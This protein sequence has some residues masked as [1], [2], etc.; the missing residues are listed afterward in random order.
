MIT[1]KL[2]NFE[3]AGLK[4]TKDLPD[5]NNS[6]QV[7]AFDT[8]NGY[9]II[10]A[11]GHFSADNNQSTAR[12]ICERIKYYLDNE[13]LD[14][15]GEALYNA[16]AYTNGFVFELK[17]K[18][19]LQRNVLASVAC[20]L[21]KNSIAYFAWMG[22]TSFLFFNGKRTY[23]MGWPLVSEDVN[24]SEPD[25]LEKR[26]V[27]LGDKQMA[28]PAVCEQPIVPVDG[29]IFL[30]GVGKSWDMIK[31]K[32]YNGI[33]ADSMPSLTKAQRLLGIAND[34]SVDDALALQL[35][36]FYNL[37]NEQIPMPPSISELNPARDLGV[38]T[39]TGFIKTIVNKQPLK[40]RIIITVC[41]LAVAYM[42]YDLFLRDPVSII[43]V[44]PPATEINGDNAVPT[45]TGSVD[46]VE[47]PADV[48]YTV[49]SGDTWAIIFTKFEVCS[50]FIRNHQPNSGR[51]D[52][53]ENPIAGT[54]I[55]IPVMYSGN[56]EMNPN[57][58][59]D[60]SLDKLGSICQ[61]ANAEFRDAFLKRVNR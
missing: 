42:F 49:Q 8:P 51:F 20:I 26:I 24:N 54:S 28:E 31:P 40:K 3:Y 53:D 17:R 34:V 58:Y 35:V 55:F 22:E 46:M 16:L 25:E 43:N 56:R 45:D 59:N 61:N 1:K 21:V 48:S 29:D 4:A 41:L 12:I 52:R 2:K 33:L 47:L 6:S 11:I 27:F 18:K 37:E 5:S 10:A 38:K 9:A 32:A 60:F 44:V 57:F 13:V 7:E 30:A 39:E 19:D 50:W 14:N 23:P 15:P 36:S